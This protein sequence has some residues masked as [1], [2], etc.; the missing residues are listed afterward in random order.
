MAVVYGREFSDFTLSLC[1]AATSNTIS[2][3]STKHRLS[4]DYGDVGRSHHNRIMEERKARLRTE[5]SMMLHDL[6]ALQRE[7]QQVDTELA[8]LKRDKISA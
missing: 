1:G 5:N 6:E 8:E 3:V 4:S 2:S 7:L